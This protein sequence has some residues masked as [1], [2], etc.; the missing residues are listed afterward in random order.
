MP[1]LFYERNH[2]LDIIGSQAFMRPPVTYE[3]HEIKLLNPLYN[4]MKLNPK[5][6][7]HYSVPSNTKCHSSF[8][9][10]VQSKVK[11]LQSVIESMTRH[12]KPALLS[13]ALSYHSDSL[14]LVAGICA[15]QRMIDRPDEC[16]AT[17]ADIKRVISTALIVKHDTTPDTSN[18]L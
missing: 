2:A 9:K 8:V 3:T 17:E 11:S 4:I 10:S 5:Y 12:Q 18:V 16:T 1:D 14:I 7:A 6:A 15:L 13:T